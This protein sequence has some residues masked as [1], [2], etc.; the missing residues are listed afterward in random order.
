MK[1]NRIRL[2]ESQLHG[3]IKESVINI[4]SESS[5]G[6]KNVSS[7]HVDDEDDYCGTR[8]GD[9]KDN[10]YYQRQF[11]S[12]SESDNYKGQTNGWRPDPNYT[13]K[14]GKVTPKPSSSEY[15]KTNIE[16]KPFNTDEWQEQYRDNRGYKFSSKGSGPNKQWKREKVS[17][18]QLHNIVKKTIAKILNES[19]T[20]TVGE[21]NI[22]F[23]D[24]NKTIISV[25]GWGVRDQQA[26]I[27]TMGEDVYQQA[28]QHLNGGYMNEAYS[29]PQLR[30]IVKQSI[31]NLLVEAMPNGYTAMQYQQMAN[32][33]NSTGG[34]TGSYHMP[35]VP[36]G[37]N[38]EDFYKQ[39]Q[40]E[41]E[42]QERMKKNAEDARQ[43]RMNNINQKINIQEFSEYMNKLEVNLAN[44]WRNVYN[45]PRASRDNE[46][47][48]YLIQDLKRKYAKEAWGY[49]QKLGLDFG[50][51]KDAVS[52]ARENGLYDKTDGL[53]GMVNRFVMGY[54]D[55]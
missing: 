11:D 3:I 26:A 53:A 37:M 8:I 33:H 40:A 50:E 22:K 12:I 47:A 21:Y 45:N 32:Q 46:Y 19:Q 31:D 15:S 52:C 10:E 24:D 43:T 49:A 55:L 13:R 38:A 39:L 9:P 2:T 27:K 7:Y 5:W 42:A 48:K 29:Q 54:S 51:F 6:G 1:K 20:V 4:L 34:F 30:R 16:P 17:E 36:R 23:D 18:S 25:N 35:S 28:L 41:K 14:N 44:E